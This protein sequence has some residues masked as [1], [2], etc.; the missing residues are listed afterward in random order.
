MSMFENDQ[1]C[2]VM[3]MDMSTVDSL[4][5][6][7]AYMNV[8]VRCNTLINEYGLT[9]VGALGQNLLALM[10]CECVG[11]SVMHSQGY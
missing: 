11:G 7:Q 3:K 5:G 8:F 9:K 6:L 10:L 2:W 4:D 1:G